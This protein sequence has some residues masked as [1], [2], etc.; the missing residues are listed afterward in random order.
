MWSNPQETTETTSRLFQTSI[1]LYKNIFFAINSIFR[2][3]KDCFSKYHL[4][5]HLIYFAVLKHKLHEAAPYRFQI[6]EIRFLQRI[7]LRLYLLSMMWFLK[8]FNKNPVDIGENNAEAVIQRCSAKK[9]L[10]KISKNSQET[11]APGSLRPA[12]LLKK[13]LWQRCFPPYFAKFLRTALLQNISE[14]L[15]LMMQIWNNLMRKL[16]KTEHIIDFITVQSFTSLFSGSTIEALY[17]FRII[18][19]KSLRK[20]T[21]LIDM[22]TLFRKVC[23][24]SRN[25]TSKQFAHEIL[26]SR[27]FRRYQPG[28]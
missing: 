3:P 15:L 26:D 10:L 2:L 22:N 8:L 28:L 9:L 11:P 16:T 25:T 18:Q 23:G 24:I 19:E 27:N 21:S 14:R 13:R 17:F 4:K 12:T 20:K 7:S 6:Q 5:Y 1:L